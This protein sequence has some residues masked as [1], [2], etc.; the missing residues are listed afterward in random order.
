MAGIQVSALDH[1]HLYGADPQAAAGWYNRVL[2][3]VVHPSSSLRDPAR[4]VYLAT[5]RGQY[6]ATF[7]KGVPPSDGDHTTAFRVSGSVFA[8]FGDGLPDGDILGRSGAPLRRD[9]AD[10]HGPAWSYY[11]QDPDGNHLEIT[12]YDHE[13]VR[14]WFAA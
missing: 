3:L 7:F 13:R 6:C 1:V 5:P 9:E 12:T 4:S 2:G 14:K 8:A 11:F 10:D